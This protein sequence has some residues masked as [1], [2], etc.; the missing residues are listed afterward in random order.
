MYRRCSLEKKI[1]EW[2]RSIRKGYSSGKS[3]LKPQLS[4]ST[5]M[6]EIEKTDNNQDGWYL[7][8]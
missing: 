7:E 2:P 8:Q 5:Q 6:T 3:K 4:T 1:T